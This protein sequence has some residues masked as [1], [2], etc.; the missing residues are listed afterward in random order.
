MRDVL[1]ERDPLFRL[2]RRHHPVI[3]NAQPPVR[4][5][6]EVPRVRIRVKKPRLQELHH[7]RVQQRLHELRAQRPGARIGRDLRELFPVDPL[8]REDAAPADAAI[9]VRDFHRASHDLD[10]RH[11]RLEPRRLLEE[12][13]RGD[14]E[15][16]DE[17]L[18]GR[19]DLRQDVVPARRDRRLRG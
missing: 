18:R 16:G 4:H 3:E 6:H 14:V 19:R 10:A 13:L 2:D 11:V 15:D 7:V 8:L 12:S 1:D 5:E 9:D 17:P